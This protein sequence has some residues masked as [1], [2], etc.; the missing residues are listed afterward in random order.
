MLDD[1]VERLKEEIILAQQLK[2][3]N[4]DK[5]GTETHSKKAADIFYKTGLIYR[6]LSPDK[7]SLIKSTV[8]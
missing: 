7:I 8:Y 6:T 5:S 1:D 4:C 3:S 2:E